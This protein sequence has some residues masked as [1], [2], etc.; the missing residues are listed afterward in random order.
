[1][2]RWV[3]TAEVKSQDTSEGDLRFD[4]S[5]W[6]KVFSRTPSQVLSENLKSKFEILALKS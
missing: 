1:M 3:N 4:L 5:F 6:L 2:N